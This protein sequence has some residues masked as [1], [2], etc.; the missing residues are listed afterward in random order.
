MQVRVS[1]NIEYPLVN[2]YIAMEII[3]RWFFLPIKNGDF[4]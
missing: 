3:T 1:M 4:L 2:V